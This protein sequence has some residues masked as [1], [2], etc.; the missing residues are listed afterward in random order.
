MADETNRVD[1]SHD[2][3]FYFSVCG[4]LT[5]YGR[6]GWGLGTWRRGQRAAAVG[7]CSPEYK[8]ASLACLQLTPDG[9]AGA[10]PCGTVASATLTQV[11]DGELRFKA[12][13]GSYCH[14]SGV[15]RTF[16]LILACSE[17]TIV[18]RAGARMGG[19]HGRAASH[20]GRAGPAVLPRRV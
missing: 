16:E 3:E 4:G 14:T 18:V 20:A 6:L 5:R 7:R 10:H 8:Y 1:T 12:V 13:D 2:Y 19:G 15:N 17:N 11:R 9:S